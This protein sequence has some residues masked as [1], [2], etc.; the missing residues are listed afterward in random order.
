MPAPSSSHFL[1]IGL[2]RRWI[3]SYEVDYRGEAEWA[4]KRFDEQFPSASRRRSRPMAHGAL[5]EERFLLEGGSGGWE[6]GVIFRLAE[7]E[8]VPPGE[9]DYGN[10]VQ[11]VGV[12]PRAWL[13]RCICMRGIPYG[14]KREL[15]YEFELPY[16][17][18]IGLIFDDLER[19]MRW[20]RARIVRRRLALAMALHPRLG[21]A[22]PLGELGLDLV[23]RV[24]DMLG[25]FG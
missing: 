18:A 14:P 1:C 19:L 15:Y 25:A 16:W 20:R 7:T 9:S 11:F 6:V 2:R 13:S 3:A 5:Y 23:Q 21:A 24:A 4:L 12:C 17:R 22:S 10:F 8:G